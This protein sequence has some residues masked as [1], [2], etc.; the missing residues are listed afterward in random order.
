MSQTLKTYKRDRMVALVRETAPSGHAQDWRPGTA[1]LVGVA[2]MA[3]G[4]FC[5][6]WHGQPTEKGPMKEKGELVR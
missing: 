2:G 3:A 6:E 4:Y 5:E 1:K